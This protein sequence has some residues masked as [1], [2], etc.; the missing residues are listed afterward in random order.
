[1]AVKSLA[2]TPGPWSNNKW[3]CKA[4]IAFLKDRRNRIEELIANHKA[5]FSNIANWGTLFQ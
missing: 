1:M 4:V 3:N 5:Q 2:H